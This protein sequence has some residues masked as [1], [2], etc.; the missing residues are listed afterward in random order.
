MLKTSL[1]S[2]SRLRTRRKTLYG[3]AYAS[4]S[5]SRTRSF[6]LPNLSL[7]LDPSYQTLLKD[8]DISLTKNKLQQTTTHRELEVVP[9]Q[10]STLA[11]NLSLK[12]WSPL[13]AGDELCS[14]EHSEDREHRKS[15]AAVFGSKQIGTVVLPQELQTVIN[16]L[17][18]S[19]C[20]PSIH[21]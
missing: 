9:D 1:L 19:Q 11:N 15:P 12:N 10:I 18:A 6:P 17:I 13:D 4:F 7:D 16:L 14:Q 3:F 8:V 21:T 20:F 2:P 5:S